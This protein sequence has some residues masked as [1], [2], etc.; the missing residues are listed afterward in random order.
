MISQKSRLEI[1]EAKRIEAEQQVNILQR[2][3]CLL[4]LRNT[5][6]A[7][8][9]NFFKEQAKLHTCDDLDSL[10]GIQNARQRGNSISTETDIE[11]VVSFF[12]I[13]YL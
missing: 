8:E 7:D 5:E 3:I 2:E 9:V 6:L 10:V 1:A 4:E 11:S 12:A 13:N